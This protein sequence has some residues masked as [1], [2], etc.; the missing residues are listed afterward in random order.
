M[1]KGNTNTEVPSST[2]L[3]AAAAQGITLNRGRA[4]EVVT[5]GAELVVTAAPSAQPTVFML[6]QLG[7]ACHRRGD[8]CLAL[9]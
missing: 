3:V 9:A 2:R 8:L 5:L 7:I 4:E 1:R 6:R